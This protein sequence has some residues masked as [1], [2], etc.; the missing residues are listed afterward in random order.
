MNYLK[1]FVSFAVSAA[2]VAAVII[3]CWTLVLYPFLVGYIAV[4]AGVCLVA[5]PIH[6]WLWYR[7][8]KET[9]NG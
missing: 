2:L 1:M 4:F 5:M 8:P 9:N 3:I 7:D 6:D